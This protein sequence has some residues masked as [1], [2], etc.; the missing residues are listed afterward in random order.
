MSA[1]S[2]MSALHPEGRTG[3]R[4]TFS[5]IRHGFMHSDKVIR[6]LWDVNL[7]I[8]AGQ[9]VCLVGP[10]GCGKTTLLGMAA[11]IVRAWE[12]LVTLDDRPVTRP[13]REVAYML[14]RD[15]LLPWLTS[16]ENAELGLRVRGVSK[17]E[18]AERADAWLAR[19]GLADFSLSNILRLSQGMRQ[20]VAIAR[21]LAQEPRCILMD[22]PF[23][24]LDAQTRILVQQSFMRLW[25]ETRAT[26]IFV[27]HDLAEALLLGDRIVL[28][29]KRP[30][31]IIAD[32]SV[33]LARPRELQLP[34]NNLGFVEAHRE[35]SRKLR[36]EVMAE[37]A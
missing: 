30:G 3:V 1:E 6:A 9:F 18:R 2:S 14:A 12:G 11:G 28:M 13:P 31:R 32:I 22:E 15:A 33:P 10:S 8:P 36:D 7:D 24:A 4:V 26:V 21:T 17:K 25:E 34:H 5:R 19:V 27:T 20:R 29:S 37:E 16:R 35:L 23:A